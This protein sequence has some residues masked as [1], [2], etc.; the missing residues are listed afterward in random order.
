MQRTIFVLPSRQPA[1]P[2]QASR[3][4]LP[5][6]LTSLIGREQEVVTACSLL[7]CPDIRLLTLTGT[8]GVGKTHLGLQVAINLYD[9]FADGVCFVALASISDPNLVIPTIAQALGLKETGDQPLLDFVKGSLRD[10]HLLLLLDNF[11]QVVTAAPVLIELLQA[12]PELKILITSREVLRVRGEQELPLLPLALPDLKHLPESA[13]LLEYAAVTLFI[14]RLRSIK[15]DF[16]L[17]PTNAQVIAEICVRLDGLPLALELAAARSRLLSPQ[18]LLAR[19]EHRLQLLTQGPRDVLER[20]QTL[21]NTIQWSYDLLSAEEQRLFRRLAVFAGGCT[22]EVVEAVSQALGDKTMDVLAR[23]ASLLDKSLVQKTKSMSKELHL[24]MLETIREYGLERL[25][26]SGEMEDTRRAHA[27][28]YLALAEE[29]EPELAGPQQLV[30]LERLEQEHDN[31]RAALRWSLE[32]GEDGQSR[33]TALR[34]SSALRRFWQVRGHPSEGRDWL[35]H[36]LA[37]S[38]GAMASLRAKALIAAASLA[39]TQGDTARTEALCQES[40]PLCKE[41]GDTEGTAH[42]LYLLGWIAYRKGNPASALSLTEEALI[43]FREV[44]DKDGTAWS[45]YNS[46]GLASKQGEYARAQVLIEESLALHRELGNKRGS[47]YALFQLAEILFL[48]QSDQATVHLLLEESLRFSRELGDK[49]GIAD[50][51]SL[52]GQLALQQ[53]DAAKA[54]SL[55]EESVLLYREMG[56]RWGTA[57]SF[58]LLGRVATFQGDHTAARALYEESLALAREGNFKWHIALSL[59]GLAGVVAVQ[60]EPARAARLWG[61]AE[62]LRDTIRSPI[63]PVERAL[64]ER[65]IAAAR[66]QLGEKAF[67]AAWVEGRSMPLEYVFVGQGQAMVPGQVLVVP[68]PGTTV[69]TPLTSPIGLTVREVEVLRLVARGMTNPQIAQELIISLH[70]VHTHVRSIYNKLDVTSRSAATRYAI[71]QHLL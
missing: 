42:I 45:L 62:R 1:V 63:P 49:R 15:P 65:S 57:G 24:M 35:E 71:E 68:Q 66:T 5:E 59:E 27:A 38:E 37:G 28:Y 40:M 41:L 33:E 26:T 54:R 39:M 18:A 53:G 46:A 43:L 29:A 22:L 70:T 61:T 36:A 32:Q 9:D 48:S 52:S 25:G 23:V 64:Y 10:K 34:L 13:A 12:C 19:L 58:S 6:Q 51:F 55:L 60:G 16:Q 67:A 8:G 4:N 2:G 47:A 3:H 7:R 69:K 44:G 14:Q 17:T 11:E 31:L 21:R 50:Y 56:S 20:Q 30:W